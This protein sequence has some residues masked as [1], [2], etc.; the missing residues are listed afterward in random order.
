MRLLVGSY[1][2]TLENFDAGRQSCLI[3]L[4]FYRR[5]AHDITRLCIRLESRLYH[6][7]DV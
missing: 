3:D 2:I 5:D 6:L 1:G 7:H 4:N